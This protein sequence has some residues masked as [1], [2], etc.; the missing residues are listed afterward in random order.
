MIVPF[1][2]ESIIG[3]S[4]HERNVKD[5]QDREHSFALSP[6]RLLE[7]LTEHL[8]LL[9]EQVEEDADGDCEEEEREELEKYHVCSDS[10]GYEIISWLTVKRLANVGEKRRCQDR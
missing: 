10:M 3:A 9:F 6:K 5:D 4:Q 7:L 2:V 1:H 8:M